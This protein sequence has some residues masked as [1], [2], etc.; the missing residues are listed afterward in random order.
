MRFRRKVCVWTVA[1]TAAVSAASLPRPVCAQEGEADAQLAK[2]VVTAQ[3]RVEKRQDVPVSVTALG[4]AR[5]SR[6]LS[7]SARNQRS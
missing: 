1:A 3:K 7:A 6:L 4:R 5:S 2:I